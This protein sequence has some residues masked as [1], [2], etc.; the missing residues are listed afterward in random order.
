MRKLL[1]ALILLMSMSTYAVQCGDYLSGQEL[2]EKAKDVSA[3]DL[4]GDSEEIKAYRAS[5]HNL[6]VVRGFILGILTNMP[7]SDYANILGSPRGALALHSST[8]KFCQTN[9]NVSFEQAM[10]AAAKSLVTDKVE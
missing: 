2:L 1:A 6:G 7:N 10:F 5:W 9:P 3:V 4:N 8:V